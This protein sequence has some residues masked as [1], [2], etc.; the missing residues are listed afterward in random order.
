M[1]PVTITVDPLYSGGECIAMQLPKLWYGGA[2]GCE[3]EFHRAILG[4]DARAGLKATRALP[5]F[6]DE[7][8]IVADRP[9]FCVNT[10]RDAGR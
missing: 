10:R 7:E 1:M 2:P 8:F 5:P 4:A 6:C 9:D 3:A